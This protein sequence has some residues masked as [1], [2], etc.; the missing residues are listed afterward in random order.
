MSAG[1]H[2]M[3]SPQFLGKYITCDTLG[4]IT[5]ETERFKATCFIKWAD[6]NW[7]AELL[8]DLKKGT[9]KGRDEFPK[10]VVGAYKLLI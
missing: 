8:E 6:E 3:Y 9:Y 7:Y 10:T 2:I 1:E 5:I 4:E